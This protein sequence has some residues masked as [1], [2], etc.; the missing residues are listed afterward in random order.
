MQDLSLE[1]AEEMIFEADIDGTSSLNYEDWTDT[2]VT[3]SSEPPACRC[4][5]CMTCVSAA[6]FMLRLCRLLSV[7][8]C[9]L[10]SEDKDKDE[11]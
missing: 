3:T 11:H 2:Q 9:E 10:S 1:A 6:S 7:H 4:S 8:D 5:P